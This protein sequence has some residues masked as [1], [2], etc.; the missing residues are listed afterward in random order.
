MNE[1]LNGTHKLMYLLPRNS[2]PFS[3]RLLLAENAKVIK[4]AQVFKSPLYKLKFIQNVIINT[5]KLMKRNE[6]VRTMI[7]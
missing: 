5:W 3:K 2:L 6:Q 4:Y 7:R 1:F